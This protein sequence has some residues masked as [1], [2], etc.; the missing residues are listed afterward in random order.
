MIAAKKRQSISLRIPIPNELPHT[1]DGLVETI[2]RVE[3]VLASRLI[4][5][6]PALTFVN[7][8]DQHIDPD[9]LTR[10]FQD[11]GDIV[12]LLQ[13]HKLAQAGQHSEAIE[14]AQR[15]FS[16]AES[17]VL[18]KFNA[19][20]TIEE[21]ELM[22]AMVNQ[23]PQQ[24]YYRIRLTA[25]R[26]LRQL[27]TKG[28]R[29]LKFHAIVVWETA[30]LHRLAHRY[31]GLLLN[32]VA[33]KNKGNVMWR[34]QLVFE[35]T[36]V[37][38]QV[39][40]KYNQCIRLANYSTRLSGRSDIPRLLMRIVDAIAHFIRNLESEH[41]NETAGRYSASAL[42]ICEL[43]RLMALADEDDEGLF[44]VAAKALMTK[45]APKGEAVDF[46][47]ETIG[48]IKIEETKQRA[49]DLVSRIIRSHQGEKLEGSVKTTYR[50]VYE[51]MAQP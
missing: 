5:S 22:A 12:K 29:V 19:V 37:Y 6:T 13:G 47:L 1:L 26:K 17:S 48:L 8:I 42:E 41:L 40:A 10:E 18:S 45:P 11:K 38:R 46:A 39:L 36:A 9:E 32:W 28:P 31:H 33:H 27:T 2:T 20:L 15:V 16:N 43:A 3:Q 51:N 4:I 49:Q 23:E 30:K 25:G 34:A 14:K 50:Q 35:R 7:A 44:T 24:N 21:A